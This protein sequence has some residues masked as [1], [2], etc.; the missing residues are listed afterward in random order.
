LEADMDLIKDP[1]VEEV[2]RSRKKHAAKFNNDIDAIVK[3]IKKRQ[4]K[5]G[6]RLVSHAP[7]LKLRKTGTY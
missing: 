4:K 3:D 7:K 1:I 2:R 5:Y 6:K